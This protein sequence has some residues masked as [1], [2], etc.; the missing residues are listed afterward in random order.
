ML[1]AKEAAKF[2]EFPPCGLKISGFLKSSCSQPSTVQ[3]CLLGCLPDSFL[4][5]FHSAVSSG[6]NP[7]ITFKRGIFNTAGPGLQDPR[8]SGTGAA[9]GQISRDI[10]AKDRHPPSNH[11]SLGLQSNEDLR[12]IDVITRK[13]PCEGLSKVSAEERH[14]KGL[15]HSLDKG[16]KHTT[17]RDPNATE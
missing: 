8:A 11:L 10:S 4:D 1:V 3:P 15:R 17:T 16:P 2:V 5:I 7:S 14:G 12:E 9:S 13:F 6:C